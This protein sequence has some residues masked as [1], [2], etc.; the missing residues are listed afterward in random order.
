VATVAVTARESGSWKWAALQWT[1]L[2]VLG[3]VV[4]VVVFQAGQALGC[5]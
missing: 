2:T 4:A 1:Y 5:G 3:Y